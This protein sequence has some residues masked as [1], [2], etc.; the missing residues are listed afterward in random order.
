MIGLC[1]CFF[2]GCQSVTHQQPEVVRGQSPLM[3][4]TKDREFLW[5]RSVDV[6]HDYLFEIARENK[7]A[8]YIET[9]YKVG[10][11]LLEPWH[12]DSASLDERLESSLQSIRRKV[13]IHFTP[14]HDVGGY[15][16]SVEAFKESEDPYG[17]TANSPGGATFQEHTA[18]QRDLTRVVGETRPSGWISIGRDRVLEQALKEDLKLAFQR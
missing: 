14:A 3:V 9:E 18:L 16:V 13:L 2:T 7:Q 4:P 11:S 8:Q 12:K 6:L 5:E 10:A 17:L 15:F 1:L